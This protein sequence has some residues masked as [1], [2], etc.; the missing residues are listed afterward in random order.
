MVIVTVMNTFTV[1]TTKIQ[2]IPVL[3][4]YPAPIS[5]QTSS[6]SEQQSHNTQH[7]TPPHSQTG[8]GQAPLP[9]VLLFHG[10]DSCKERKLQHAYIIA[11]KGYFVVMPDAV[12][13]GEREDS[14]F[15]SLSY[16]QKAEFLFDVVTETAAEINSI[17]DHYAQSSIVDTSRC[18]LVG[19]SMGGMILYDYF[20]HFGSDRIKA[21]VS[22]ISTPDFGSVID[23]SMENNPEFYNLYSKSK[24]D[25]VKAS[26]PLSKVSTLNEFP[27]LML[28]SEDD[29]LIPILPVRDF[30]SAL[31][32][33]YTDNNLLKMKLFH[34][35]GHQTTEAMMHE[36]ADWLHKWV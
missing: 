3:E 22:I 5:Y 20:A 18:G 12:R 24:I 16:T 14:A 11:Q 21:A 15:A 31:H 13:H 23:N 6:A 7:N 30:Y 19:T 8:P 28:N 2:S 1:H 29:Q 32:H 4:M 10:F 26:Q 35:I 33:Q 36:S 34:N 9:M 25:D 27:L 17:L